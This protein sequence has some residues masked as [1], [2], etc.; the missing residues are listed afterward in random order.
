MS[1]IR[2]AIPTMGHGKNPNYMAALTAA[3]CMPLEILPEDLKSFSVQDFDGLLLPGGPDVDPG[4]FGEENCGSWR[5]DKKLDDHEF[6]VLDSFVS[7]GLPVIGICR[8]IQVINIYFGGTLHQHLKTFEAHTNDRFIPD[9]SLDGGHSETVGGGDSF[10]VHEI[11][12]DNGSWLSHLYDVNFMTNSSHHQAVRKAGEDLIIDA[13]CSLDGAVEALHH[14]K[15]PVIGLQFHPE[16]MCLKFSDERT[17]NG[18]KIFTAFRELCADVK[19][20]HKAVI[21]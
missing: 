15:L 17:V 12:A 20:G 10:L 14:T 16:R 5:I 4:R 3:G 11:H 21:R 13:R 6:S 9:G 18:L 2:I 19:A 8:G 1:E 7:A